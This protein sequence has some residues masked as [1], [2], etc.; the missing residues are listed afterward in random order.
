MV[1]SLG[2]G[3]DLEIIE[4]KKNL[5]EE[6][7]EDGVYGVYYYFPISFP[8]TEEMG[9]EELRCL[10]F[11]SGTYDFWKSPKEDIYTI[12]DGNPV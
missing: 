12:D 3:S 2:K 1:K 7:S 6:I 9:D 10:A 5:G 4:Y 8:I 11:N